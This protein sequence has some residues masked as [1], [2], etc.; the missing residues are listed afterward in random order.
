MT[1]QTQSKQTTSMLLVVL[2]SSLLTVAFSTAFGQAQ[3]APPPMRLTA[4]QTGTQTE[5]VDYVSIQVDGGTIRQV[6]NAFA[7]QTKRNVVIGPEVISEGVNIHLNRVRWDEALEAIE[8][9]VLFAPDETDLWY[10]AGLLHARF[11]HVEDAV[12]MLEEYLRRIGI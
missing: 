1:T 2:L 7:I 8:T 10:E 11:D 12:R 5:T 6:L 9:M 4:E 3:N